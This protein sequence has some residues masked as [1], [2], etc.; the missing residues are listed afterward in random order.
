MLLTASAM[1]RGLRQGRISRGATAALLPRDLSGRF[2]ADKAAADHMDWS[3]GA[4]L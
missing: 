4:G 2:A 1:D 3:Q